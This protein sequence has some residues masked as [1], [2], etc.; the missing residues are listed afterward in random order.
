MAT[1][2]QGEVFS[3]VSFVKKLCAL[4][5]TLWLS[6]KETTKNTKGIHEV[7]KVSVPNPS[8][9]VLRVRLKKGTPMRRIQ[10]INTATLNSKTIRV[11]RMRL[12]KKAHR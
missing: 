4:L 1:P 11:L 5:R 6:E 3:S 10:R 9:C 2:K 8:I 12:K 7:R